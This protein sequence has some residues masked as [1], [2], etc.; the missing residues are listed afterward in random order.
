MASKAAAVMSFPTLFYTLI[1]ACFL[2]CMRGTRQKVSS[3][4][5]VVAQSLH[6]LFSPQYFNMFILAVEN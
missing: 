4:G 1:Q 6:L 3:L 5:I 2:A